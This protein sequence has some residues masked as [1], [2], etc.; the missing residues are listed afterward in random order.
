MPAKTVEQI[1]AESHSLRGKITETLL[2]KDQSHFA[3]EEFQLLKFHGTYQQ[4]DRDQRASRKQQRLDKAW[5]FMVRSKL[6]GGGLS[7]SQY[8]P[9][10]PK[11]HELR[12]PTLLSTTRQQ[13]HPPPILNADL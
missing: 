8:L 3:D 6:P 7:A 5:E 10:D 4:D 1:K 9:H 13:F 11:A 2:Q 12:N